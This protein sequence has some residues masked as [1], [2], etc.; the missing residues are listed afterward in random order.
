[1]IAVS[2]SIW[3]FLESVDPATSSSVLGASEASLSAAIL[4]SPLGSSVIIFNGGFYVV[5]IFEI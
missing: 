5:G 1:M 4:A 2:E 3:L